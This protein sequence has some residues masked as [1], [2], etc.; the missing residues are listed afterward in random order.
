MQFVSALHLSIHCTLAA[1]PDH[2]SS[3]FSV[4]Q[5]GRVPLHY[6][7]G[8]G[9]IEAMRALV[10]EFVVVGSSCLLLLSPVVC[11]C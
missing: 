11:C 10:T 9:H 7:A 8:G 1:E 3:A 5:N 2:T 6:A 4:F